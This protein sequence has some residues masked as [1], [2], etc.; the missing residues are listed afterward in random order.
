ME[1]EIT[2]YELN[3]SREAIE[4]KRDTLRMVMKDIQWRSH[5]ETLQTEDDFKKNNVVQSM[6]VQQIDQTQLKYPRE[7]TQKETE[8][9]KNNNLL[10]YFK[11]NTTIVYVNKYEEMTSLSTDGNA[12][13]QAGIGMKSIPRPLFGGAGVFFGLHPL[14][15]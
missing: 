11:G 6:K 5:N 8:F 4:E 1:V 15:G 7:Q 2:G 9:N 14:A 13:A 12:S 3:E 10:D